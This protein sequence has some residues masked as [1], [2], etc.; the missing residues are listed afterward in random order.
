[1]RRRWRLEIGSE[2]NIVAPAG[3]TFLLAGVRTVGMGVFNAR[4]DF[5]HVRIA[6]KNVVVDAQIESL[7]AVGCAGIGGIL[8]VALFPFHGVAACRHLVAG[9]PLPVGSE[10]IGRHD[11]DAEDIFRPGFHADDVESGHD[12]RHQGE[13]PLGAFPGEGHHIPGSRALILGLE[14]VVVPLV[15]GLI[16]GVVPPLGEVVGIV[17][18]Q[19]AFLQEYIVGR[20]IAQRSCH[21][22]VVLGIEGGFNAVVEAARSR[23]AVAVQP[24]ACRPAELVLLAGIVHLEPVIGFRTELVDQHGTLNGQDGGGG[25]AVF[26]RDAGL[27]LADGVGDRAALVLQVQLIEGIGQAGSIPGVGFRVV[28]FQTVHAA[29]VPD[30][31]ELEVVQELHVEAGAEAA[32]FV[33]EPAAVAFLFPHH[34]AFAVRIDPVQA[35][36]HAQGNVEFLNVGVFIV[37]LGIKPFEA[38]AEPFAGGETAAGRQGASGGSRGRRRIGQAG[39]SEGQDPD[40][41]ESVGFH[42]VLWLVCL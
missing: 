4:H 34:A 42:V 13:I 30:V 22:A 18:P 28:A 26:P 32:P 5:G 19:A 12:L 11:S 21:K 37:P 1:M 40:D 27:D 41:G 10:F 29:D 17:Q 20:V 33:V 23:A 25:R 16:L 6:F 8:R 3:E 35:V 38:V 9:H 24:D 15:V 31:G 39:G 36:L 2:G 14:A 7:H